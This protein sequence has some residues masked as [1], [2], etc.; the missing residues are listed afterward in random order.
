MDERILWV[1]ITQKFFPGSMRIPELLRRY[2]SIRRIY[3]ESEY[4]DVNLSGSEREALKDKSLDRAYEICSAVNLA[5]AR[6]LVYDDEKYP[7]ALRHIDSPPYVLYVKGKIIDWSEYLLIGVVGTRNYSKYGL[8][9]TKAI[10]GELAARGAVIVTGLARGL[11]AAATKEA[12]RHNSYTVVV[13]AYAI[14][15]AIPYE[16]KAIFEAVQKTGI[17]MSEFPPGVRWSKNYIPIRN[18]IIAGLSRGVLVTEAP[19]KSGTLIT[20]RHAVEYGRDV[21]AVPGSIFE[22]SYAGC[23]RLLQNSAKCTMSAQDILDEYH[24]VAYRRRA[25]MANVFIG[26]LPEIEVSD[27]RIDPRPK[28]TKKEPERVKPKKSED[29]EE[30][31]PSLPDGLEEIERKVAVC[32][33][34]GEKH[35]DE[36]IRESGVDSGRVSTTLVLLEMKGIVAAL[37]SNKYKLK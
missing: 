10:V 21:F 3:D 15:T 18:R 19:E 37:P 13:N 12:L 1:W 9:A 2:E 32:L 7:E 25:P 24:D 16:N 23:N 27:E 22:K 4:D 36:I 31:K 33:L 17:I 20:V 26:D 28:K 29:G 6:I 11:D 30:K 5:N 35:R 8:A 14:D 34:E